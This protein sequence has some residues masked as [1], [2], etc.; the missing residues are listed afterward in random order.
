M[1]PIIPS[2]DDDEEEEEE[3]IQPV[4]VEELAPA[5]SSLDT[6][7]VKR[8]WRRVISFAFPSGGAPTGASADS[9][10]HATKPESTTTA[11]ARPPRQ[12]QAPA[13]PPM[14]VGYPAGAAGPARRRRRPPPYG[15]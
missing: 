11:A 13:S 6:V 12:A 5:A 4:D 3:E 2:S 15:T 8:R 14:E 7:V 10:D 9:T 1:P